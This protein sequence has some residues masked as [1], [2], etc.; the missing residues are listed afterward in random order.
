MHRR[1][2]LW[3]SGAAVGIAAVALCAYL[4]ASSATGPVPG[5]A[6]QDVVEIRRAAWRAAWRDIVPSL[7]FRDIRAAPGKLWFAY[8]YLG[9]VS[10]PNSKGAVWCG[11]LVPGRT[12]REQVDY[13]AIKQGG[14]W[15]I[16][17]VVSAPS[18]QPGANETTGA[19]AGGP[20][21]LQMRTLCAARI[22]PQNGVI[23][24][25]V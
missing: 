8:R 25:P 2:W 1:T 19:N 4:F 7:S 22:L 24:R 12:G 14:H 11:I 17:R 3:A 23:C 10:E 18:Q 16:L 20:R 5:L 6:R 15:V 13:L 9:R 21:L